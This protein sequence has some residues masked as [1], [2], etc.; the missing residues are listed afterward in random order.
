MINK[1]DS[2]VHKIEI[3]ANSLTESD[4]IEF[5]EIGEEIHYYVEEWKKEIGIGND[6]ESE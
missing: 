5:Q 4:E 3:F 2:K 6:E 1:D